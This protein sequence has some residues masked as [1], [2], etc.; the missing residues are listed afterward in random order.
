MLIQARRLTHRI[1]ERTILDLPGF[2]MPRGEHTVLLGPSGCGKTTLINI[3]TG[4][5]TPTSGEVFIDGRPMT[6]ARPAAR[7]ALRRECIGLV[8]QTLRLVS[9]LTVRQNLSLAQHLAGGRSD[10]AEIDR[11]IAQVG[12]SHRAH[13]RPRELSQGE[14]Q[15]AAIA[16][17]LCARPALLV[18]DEPTSALDDANAGA[19]IDL[20]L[21]SAESGG[22]T[23]LIATHDRRIRERFARTVELEPVALAA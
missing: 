6:G 10:E 18:A 19:M 15:R 8:F 13:A 17:A 11:L 22:S 9:A 23:L 7:D 5:V 4:L 14:S 16:R 12:L 3:L 20:L 1:A 21:A 2:E